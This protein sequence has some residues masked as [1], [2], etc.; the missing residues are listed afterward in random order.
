MA[1][2]VA[3]HRPVEVAVASPVDA[4]K[5]RWMVPVVPTG[6]RL[7]EVPLEAAVAAEAAIAVADPFE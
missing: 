5:L 4:A 6:G 1:G 3:V 2:V 7:V